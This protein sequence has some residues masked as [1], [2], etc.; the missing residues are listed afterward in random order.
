M[1]CSCW[2]H[3]LCCKGNKDG[4]CLH[5]IWGHMGWKLSCSGGEEEGGEEA[6]F[7][8]H[9]LSCCLLPCSHRHHW[10][11]D[12]AVLCVPPLLLPASKPW[13]RGPGITGLHCSCYPA[14]HG[15]RCSFAA[16]QWV[17]WG[18]GWLAQVPYPGIQDLGLCLC[19]SSVKLPLG[20]PI[21]PLSHIPIC[22]SFW[23]PAVLFNVAFLGLW[24]YYLL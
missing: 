18:W 7:A 2:W 16:A 17:L 19:C 23:C 14:S 12:L 24:M 10:V 6:S 4:W 1:P 9:L 15:Y 11:W 21:H 20:T 22:G 3:W 5:H 13:S 8:R